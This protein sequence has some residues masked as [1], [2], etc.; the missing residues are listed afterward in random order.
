MVTFGFSGMAAFRGLCCL[1]GS[2]RNPKSFPE[3]KQVY[4]RYLD[5]PRNLSRIDYPASFR[6]IEKILQKSFYIA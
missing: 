5:H 2:V 3:K 1:C 4:H 6:K